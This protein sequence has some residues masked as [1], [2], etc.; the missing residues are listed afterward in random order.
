MGIRHDSTP[1]GFV[2]MGITELIFMK[3]HQMSFDTN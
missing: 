2:K 3:P 1:I